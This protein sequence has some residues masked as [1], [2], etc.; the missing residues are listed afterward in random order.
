MHIALS[1]FRSA[2]AAVRSMIAVALVGFTVP[3]HATAGE[4]PPRGVTDAEA[5]ERQVVKAS[6]AWFE[7][8]MGPD[9][10]ALDRMQ[11]DD[12]V[13]VQQGPQGWPSWTKPR[14]WGICGRP[15]TAESSSSAICPA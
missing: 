3:P 7:A 4:Q 2:R 14:S 6:T 9:I 11:T 1:P 13:T 15:V 8:L 10:E 5:I 12:F